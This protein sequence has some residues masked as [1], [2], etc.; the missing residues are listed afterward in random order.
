MIHH[1]MGISAF[2]EFTVLP[3]IA[4]AKIPKEAPLAKASVMGCAVATGMGAVRNTA[5]VEC[6]SSGLAVTLTPVAG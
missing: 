5:K 4:V 2:S 3:E 1:D 6:P